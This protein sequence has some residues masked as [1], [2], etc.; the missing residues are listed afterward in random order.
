MRSIA[1]YV[2][3]KRKFKMSND[4]KFILAIFASIGVTFAIVTLIAALGGGA[5]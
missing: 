2:K 4:Q 1:L 5:I 3:P